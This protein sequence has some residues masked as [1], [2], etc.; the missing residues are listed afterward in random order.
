M[1]ADRREEV[2]DVRAIDVMAK[3]A[4]KPNK[5]AKKK[6]RGKPFTGKDDPR[7]GPG[8]PKRGQSW[9]EIIKEIG[10]LT[11]DEARAM[12]QKI[13]AQIQLGNEITLKQAVVLRVYASMLFEP[14]P[15][16]INAFMDRA[17]GKVS[18]PVE[19]Y[20]WRSE[21]AKQGYDPNKLYS[22]LVNAARARLVESGNSGS[23]AGSD[24][25]A[26][27]ADRVAD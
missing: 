10:E 1:R 16:L 2:R 4:V 7:N 11:P 22:D 27:R 26:D 23:D 14:Q 20:D 13:F 17:D 8:A 9:A 5:S 6:P 24:D 3:L 12:S 18:Q 25:R 21:A 15:G 19:V